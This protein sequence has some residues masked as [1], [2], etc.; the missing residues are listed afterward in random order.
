[1]PR[2]GASKKCSTS[3]LTSPSGARCLEQRELSALHVLENFLHPIIQASPKLKMVAAACSRP[4]MPISPTL[5]LSLVRIFARTFLLP[6]CLAVKASSRWT[7][8]NSR[9]SGG[10]QG[11]RNT[12]PTAVAK[13]VQFALVGAV[14]GSPESWS[15]K[16]RMRSPVRVSAT[17]ARSIRCRKQIATN[18]F[19]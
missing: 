9:G 12:S 6:V 3:T 5:T 16:C 1:M 4:G 19:D 11:V 13:S 7:L 8:E 14:R 10:R 17:W 15:R 18:Q 2:Q